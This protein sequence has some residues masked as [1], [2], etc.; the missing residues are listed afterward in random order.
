VTYVNRD[1]KPAGPNTSKKIVRRSYI[2]FTP[3]LVEDDHVRDEVVLAMLVIQHLRGMSGV[4]QND[5]FWQAL[6]GVL[7]GANTSGI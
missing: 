3:K 1:V 7:T 6:N 5:S 2:E 4:K